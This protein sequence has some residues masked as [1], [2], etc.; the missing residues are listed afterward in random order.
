MKPFRTA[1]LANGV[2]AVAA[3]GQELMHVG[4]VTHIED[5]AV[6]RCVENRVQRNRQLHHAQI[7]PQMAAGFGQHGNEFLADLL[8]QL[9][10]LLHRNLFDIGGELMESRRRAIG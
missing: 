1:R 6:R 3:S 5:K 2:E 10:K 7:R 9:G 8:G 4:L